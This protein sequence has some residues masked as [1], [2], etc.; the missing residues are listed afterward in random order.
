MPAHPQFVT[1]AQGTRT[2]V[3]IPLE[4]YQ[5]LLEDLNDLAAVAERRQEERVSLE[6]VK[7][8]L[9]ADGLL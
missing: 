2:A 4:E 3:L 1:D 5:S 7:Q 8:Q 9:E 6:E